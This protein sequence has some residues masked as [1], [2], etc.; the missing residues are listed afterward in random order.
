MS[1]C[2]SAPASPDLT[3][4]SEVKAGGHQGLPSRMGDVVLQSATP[5]ITQG[6]EVIDKRNSLQL[7]EEVQRHLFDKP[8]K[9]RQ[10]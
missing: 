9:S 6:F 2:S 10:L 5:P 4:Q 7:V 8:L 3:G 1:S